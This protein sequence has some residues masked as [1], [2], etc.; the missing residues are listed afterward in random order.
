MV[1]EVRYAARLQAGGRANKKLLVSQHAASAWMSVVTP[2]IEQEEK[3]LLW[4]QN[5][6]L[7]KM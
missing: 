3:C 4:M 2:F 1:A 7:E 6:L 5:T